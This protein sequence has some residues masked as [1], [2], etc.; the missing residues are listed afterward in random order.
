MMPIE[1][2][3]NPPFNKDLYPFEFLIDWG[4]VCID[5]SKLAGA[6]FTEV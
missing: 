3:H 4:R 2:Y 6:E 1:Y 5:G